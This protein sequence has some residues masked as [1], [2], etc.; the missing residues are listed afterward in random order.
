MGMLLIRCVANT[1]LN[2]GTLRGECLSLQAYAISC[3][4][5]LDMHGIQYR[6]PPFGF[7]CG[8]RGG[9]RPEG[10]I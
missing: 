6:E 5:Q 8:R 7:L 10:C 1:P 3:D 9:I 2:R 4:Q